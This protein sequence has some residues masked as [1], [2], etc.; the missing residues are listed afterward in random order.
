MFSKCKFWLREVGFLGH[1]ISEDGIKF[2]LK[3]TWA[4][5]NWSKLLPPSYISRLF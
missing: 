1:I 5:T 4:A 3:K 2:Y